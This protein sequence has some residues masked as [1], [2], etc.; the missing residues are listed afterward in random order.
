MAYMVYI[1]QPECQPCQHLFSCQ[2]DVVALCFC[3]RLD[4]PGWSRLINVACKW[5]KGVLDGLD[6]S[7]ER[8]FWFV[9]RF[10]TGN[11]RKHHKHPEAALIPLINRFFRCY[12]QHTR[13]VAQWHVLHLSRWNAMLLSHPET[14]LQYFNGIFLSRCNFLQSERHEH[15][16][17]MSCHVPLEFRCGQGLQIMN[18]GPRI[19]GV[20]LCLIYSWSLSQI[21]VPHFPWLLVSSG[22]QRFVMR[23]F[24]PCHARLMSAVRFVWRASAGFSTVL[25]HQGKSCIES[26]RLQHMDAYGGYC[27]VATLI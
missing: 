5:W 1:Y 25:Q 13:Q 24:L 26:R 22:I 2:G 19:F 16:R 4:A 6:P 27:T 18:P 17:A 11:N 10:A 8:W 20:L 14:M 3:C 9:H 15:M 23:D 21:R 7:E 12:V